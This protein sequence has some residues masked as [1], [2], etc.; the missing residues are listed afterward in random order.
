[1]AIVRFQIE[2]ESPPEVVLERIRQVVRP[3]PDSVEHWSRL[4]KRKDASGPPFV[5][6]VLDDSFR[7]RRDFQG[8]NSFVPLIRG[9]I[10]KSHNGSR[11]KGV[12]FLHP[13]VAL[14]IAVWLGGVSYGALTTNTGP[15]VAL[16]GMFGFGV[17]L[18]AGGFS[19][20]VAKAKRLLR[21]AVVPDSPGENA[22]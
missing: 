16:W 6:S 17:A 3:K 22:K 2:S 13:F 7:I 9:R 18:T 14:F 1:M 11:V 4:W 19:V 5:G 12:M 21:A 15:P 10:I 8:Q 20:E